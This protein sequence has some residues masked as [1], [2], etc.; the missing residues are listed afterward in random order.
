MVLGGGE[1]PVQLNLE[2]YRALHLASHS[3]PPFEA[4]AK[5]SCFMKNLIKPCTY[6]NKT[7]VTLN[8]PL[9]PD[10]PTHPNR[11]PAIHIRTELNIQ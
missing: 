5:N 1:I 9:H 8:P 11:L 7:V 2:S 3:T 10:F 6:N 4:P